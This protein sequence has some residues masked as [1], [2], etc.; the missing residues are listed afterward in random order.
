VKILRAW[1]LFSH[2]IKMKHVFGTCVRSMNSSYSQSRP[3]IVLLSGWAGVGKDVVAN[4]MTE[5]MGYSRLAFA[6]IVRK[7]IS[8]HTRIP[9]DYFASPLYKDSPMVKPLA[10]FPDAVTY[11]DVLIRWAS[12]RRSI[13]DDVYAQTII[14]I[15]RSGTAGKKVVISDWRFLCEEKAIVA[16]FPDATIRRVRILRAS[17]VPHDSPSEHELDA[18]PMDLELPNHGTI[19]DMR[20]LLHHSPALHV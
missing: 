2:T 4:L 7:E 15:I 5:E 20:A 16:A 3:I 12:K 17:V 8:E 11:R 9:V 13:Q 10:E 18:F 6:D 19:S 14:D 1:Q